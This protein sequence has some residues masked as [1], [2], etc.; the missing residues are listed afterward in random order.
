MYLLTHLFSIF[1][2]VPDEI[3]LSAFLL[4]FGGYEPICTAF[5]A[6]LGHYLTRIR[7]RKLSDTSQRINILQSFIRYPIKV[8]LGMYA[9]LS[10]SRNPQRRAIHDLARGSVMIKCKL[11]I[12]RVFN[13]KFIYNY[14]LYY[15]VQKTLYF[16][17]LIS[18]NT[19]QSTTSN[20]SHGT[21]DSLIKGFKR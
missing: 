16:L 9:Y 6:T 5:G 17:T 3:R 10:I 1:K 12:E 2:N 4:L 21:V 8:A 11:S 7:V 13:H 15:H 20:H 14:N 18:L 19:C